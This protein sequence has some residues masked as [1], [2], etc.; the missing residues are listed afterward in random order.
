[1]NELQHY[2]A[3]NQGLCRSLPPWHTRE[4]ADSLYRACILS[5]IHV[6]VSAMIAV[7][8]G[9]RRRRQQQI[10]SGTQCHVAQRVTSNQ[11]T[12]P[13]RRL[14]GTW[15]G[16]TAPAE[17]LRGPLHACR[18]EH[19]PPAGVSFS[20]QGEEMQCYL[21]TVSDRKKICALV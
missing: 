10:V 5:S 14:R 17:P 3:S 11:T 21:N 16:L 19:D 7:P 9:P 4:K 18:R 20:A 15:R 12:C 2:S 13:H 1:L 8:V 6:R